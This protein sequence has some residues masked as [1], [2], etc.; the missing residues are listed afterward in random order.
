MTIRRDLPSSP[1]SGAIARVHGGE[2]SEPDRAAHALHRSNDRAAEP[3]RIAWRGQRRRPL[4]ADHES[5][6][7]DNGRP[8]L[9]WHATCA[10]ALTALALSLPVAAALVAQPG[11][12]VVVLGARWR[13]PPW[14]SSPPRPSAPWLRWSPMSSSPGACSASPEHG[15]TSTSFA[16][17]QVNAP[18]SLRRDGESSSPPPTKLARRR[19]SASAVGGPHPPRHQCARR[20]DDDLLAAYRACGVAVHVAT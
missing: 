11:V 17:A 14:P 13:A 19:P 8:A 18:P 5:V 4:I 10:G 15:L 20:P 12:D 2:N 3:K 16:D 9:P 7:M 1:R 6:V